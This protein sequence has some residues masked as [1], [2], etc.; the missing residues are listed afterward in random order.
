MTV[1]AASQAETLP[2][3]NLGRAVWRGTLCRCPSC[4]EGKLF[5]AYL[6]VANQCEVCGEEYHQHRA[7]DLPPYIAIFIVGHVLVGVM[8]HLDMVWKV[9]PMVYLATLVPLAIVL[10]L[11]MLPSCKGA[12]VGLQWAMRMHGFHPRH[13]E[14]AGQ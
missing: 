9:S 10:P 7:D 13:R 14:R 1:P 4:G 2:E 12:V 3:R 11:L 5:R 8:L 6:K